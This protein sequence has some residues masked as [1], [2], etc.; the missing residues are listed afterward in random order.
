[1]PMFILTPPFYL[2]HHCLTDGLSYNNDGDYDIQGL[3]ARDNDHYINDL[4]NND[5]YIKKIPRRPTK[6]PVRTGGGG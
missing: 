6:R 1:M 5:H 3:T 2:L 4:Y